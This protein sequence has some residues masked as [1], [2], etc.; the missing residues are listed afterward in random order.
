MKCTPEYNEWP[1]CGYTSNVKIINNLF[2]GLARSN[3]MW[4]DWDNRAGSSPISIRVNETDNT[5]QDLAGHPQ[6]EWSYSSDIAYCMHKNIEILGNVFRGNYGRYEISLSGVTELKIFENVFESRHISAN[7]TDTKAPILILT[8]N[9]IEISN[10]T[11]PMNVTCP[12]ENRRQIG[13]NITGN[14][15]D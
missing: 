6:A 1:E 8:G 5:T 12:I 10:N 9:G 3:G 2:E 15:I 4:E 7:L 11:Y 14:D 13:Q